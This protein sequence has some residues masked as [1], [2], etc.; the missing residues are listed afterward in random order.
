MTQ[1]IVIN[2]DKDGNITSIDEFEHALNKL[3]YM[4]SLNITDQQI[5]EATH[6]VWKRFSIMEDK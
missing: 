4:V 5:I 2:T 3:I 1:T 6:K